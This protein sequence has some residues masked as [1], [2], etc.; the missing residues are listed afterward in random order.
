MDLLRLFEE[1]YRL[2]EFSGLEVKLSQIV[3]RL[4]IIRLQGKRLTKLLFR[5]VRLSGMKKARCQIGSCSGRI[6]L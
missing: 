5:R 4:E 1:R 2:R 6:R 3:I